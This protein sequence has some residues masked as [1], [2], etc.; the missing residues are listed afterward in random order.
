MFPFYKTD[1]LDRRL[2]RLSLIL[3]GGNHWGHPRSR[4]WCGPGWGVGVGLASGSVCWQSSCWNQGLEDKAQKGAPSRGS[5]RQRSEGLWVR[6]PQ[7]WARLDVSPSRF[8]LIPGCPHHH[9]DAN[10]TV[11]GCD[12]PTQGPLGIP[13]EPMVIASN[14][15]PYSIGCCTAQAQPCGTVLDSS[16]SHP[17]TQS[18]SFSLKSGHLSPSPTAASLPRLAVALLILLPSYSPGVL[19]LHWQGHSQVISSFN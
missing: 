4:A 13:G 6:N 17:P 7:D 11:G 14:Q 1:Q 9:Q 5:T 15:R 2:P 3:D 16:S 19:T 18:S 8:S 12:G 10:G